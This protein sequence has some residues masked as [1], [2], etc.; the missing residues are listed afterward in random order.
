[1]SILRV[2]FVANA[3]A[4]SLPAPL[5]SVSLPLAATP[6]PVDQ[7]PVVPVNPVAP[8]RVYARL[9]ADR[10]AYVSIANQPDPAAPSALIIVPGTT[11]LLRTYPGQ[12]VQAVQADDF[13]AYTQTELDARVVAATTAAT[14]KTYPVAIA[15]RGQ[16]VIPFSV[17]PSN[18]GSVQVGVNG[19]LYQPPDIV[20]GALAVTW[21]N[22][23]FLLDP[24]DSVTLSYV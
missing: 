9:T 10:H 17:L 13:A 12:R 20:V 19:L 5:V 6:T 2:E 24:T 7:Q 23:D 3:D 8:F 16:A 4:G 11:L 18:L 22:P 21:A 1:M 15:S 14:P